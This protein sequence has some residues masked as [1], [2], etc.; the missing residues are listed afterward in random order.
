MTNPLYDALF[1]PHEDREAPFLLLPDG[2]EMSYREFLRGASRFSHVLSSANVVQG[3]R[4]AVQVEK[5]PE[6]LMLYAACLM[7]GAIFLPLN[8]AYTDTELDYFIED[9]GAALIVL[10][11]ARAARDG[12]LTLSAAG[13]G[14]LAEAAQTMDDHFDPVAR[15]VPPTTVRL[16]AKR[17]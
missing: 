13:G 4:V 17:T 8:T 9:S 6:A 16:P 12:S 10:D 2:R 1:R 11:P 5:S 14:S 3:D 15:A 7:T